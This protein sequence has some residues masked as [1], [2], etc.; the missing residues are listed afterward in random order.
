MR[1][2]GLKHRARALAQERGLPLLP[3]SGLLADLDAARAEAERIGFPVML[4]STAGGGGIG[5]QLCRGVAELGARFAAVQRLAPNNFSEGG[6]FLEKYVERARTSKCSC[7]ETAR[8]TSS[9]WASGIAR[10]S[11][12]IR[13][14]S[15]KRRRRGSPIGTR[16]H[17]L[18]A[19]VRLGRAVGYRSAGTVEFVYDVRAARSTSSK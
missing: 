17:L 4:K 16:A 12:A 15:K 2:F 7:S 10:R 18:D 14:S 3:G 19:A 8:A 6:L 5:M 9:R 1:D 11:G 13:R